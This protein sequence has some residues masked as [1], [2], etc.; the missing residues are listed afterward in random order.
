MPSTPSTANEERVG[1]AHVPRNFAFPVHAHGPVKLEVKGHGGEPCTLLIGGLAPLG[2]KQ[3]SNFPGLTIAHERIL[4][5]ALSH[6]KFE[7]PEVKIGL[8]DLI[9]C[10]SSKSGRAYATTL[11]LLNDLANSWMHVLVPGG[12][13]RSVRLLSFEGE[14]HYRNGTDPTDAV[15]IGDENS[16][17]VRHI[18]K[19]TFAEEFWRACFNWQDC[20]AIRVDALDG[21]TS[22]LAAFAYLKLAPNTHH[23]SQA[24]G[25]RFLRDTS[26][27]LGE[28]GIETT[29]RWRIKDLFERQRGETPSVLGQMNGQ[30]MWK[31]RFMVAPKL[32]PNA[33]RLGYNLAYWRES[34]EPGRF[35]TENQQMGV[36]HQIWVKATGGPTGFFEAARQ[37]YA[38]IEPHNEDALNALGYNWASSRKFLE[39]VRSFI[40]PV[41]FDQVIG[42]VKMAVQT[43]EVG[44]PQVRD[45]GAYLGAAMVGEFSSWAKSRSLRRRAA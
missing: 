37:E 29:D 2:G 30:L 45:V 14:I 42:S 33:D 15:Q 27:L 1:V 24:P 36:L 13:V 25:A 35:E 10:S 5:R 11:R 19:L 7:S 28:A 31:D 16:I 26:A 6:R 40:G 4:L 3:N 8:G 12:P 39:R 9:R 21:M 38:T 18:K 43:A 22:D 34:E 23:S 41:A 17:Q 32:E 44:G 20:W